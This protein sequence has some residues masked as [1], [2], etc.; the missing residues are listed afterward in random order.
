MEEWPGKLC[1]N[2]AT[3]TD[4]LHFVMMLPRL[5]S[6]SSSICT[7]FPWPFVHFTQVTLH[8]YTEMKYD[9]DISIH[10]FQ[11][12]LRTF[13]FQLYSCSVFIISKTWL[14]VHKWFI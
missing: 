13:I 5:I 4:Q 14:C 2:A 12:N 8:F 11:N 3:T 6:D 1:T 10:T 9:T 7:Q